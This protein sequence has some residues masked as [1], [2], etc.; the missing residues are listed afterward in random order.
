MHTPPFA[1]DADHPAYLDRIIEVGTDMH[2]E[3]ATWDSKQ[4]RMRNRGTSYLVQIMDDYDLLPVMNFKYG[5]HPETPKIN[6]DVWEGALHTESARRLLV[7][8]HRGVA[9]TL[10]TTTPSRPAPTPVAVRS[11]TDLNTRRS[12]Q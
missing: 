2:R 11:S 10:S 12:L 1:G 5:S 6:G 4:N 3:V 9:P 8:L 7:R